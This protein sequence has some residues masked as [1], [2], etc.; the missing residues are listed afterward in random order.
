[1]V[2]T[3]RGHLHDPERAKLYRQRAA[4]ILNWAEQ[5]QSQEQ[6]RMLL[7]IAAMYHRLAKQLED[8]EPHS[9]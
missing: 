3:A 2:G 1:V 6:R 9:L 7:A 8:G 4:E 5:A